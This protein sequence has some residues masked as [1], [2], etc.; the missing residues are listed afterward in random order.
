MEYIKRGHPKKH[1]WRSGGEFSK[2]NIPW[3]KKVAGM[4]LMKAWNKGK[5]HMQKENHPL[6]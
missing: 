5:P 2:G 1:W 6:W 3:S 4:G